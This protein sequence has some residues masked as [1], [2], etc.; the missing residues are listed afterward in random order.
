MIQ[1]YAHYEKLTLDPKTQI[2]QKW[3][4]VKEKRYSMKIGTKRELG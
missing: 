4:I 1:L 3:K 2:D